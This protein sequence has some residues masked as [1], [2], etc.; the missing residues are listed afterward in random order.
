MN[1]R[2]FM[3][4]SVAAPVLLQ[5]QAEAGFTSLFTGRDLSGWSVQE[6]PESA[7]YVDK[8]DIVGTVSSDFPVWL[9]YDRQFENFD[10]RCEFFVKNWT[11][12]GVYFHAPE[13]GRNTWIGG[14]VKIFHQ[15][16]PDPRSNSMGSIFPVI[17]PKKVNVKNNGAWNSMRILMNWP[18]LTVWVNDETVQDLDMEQHPELRYRIRRG[19]MGLSALGYPLR[20]R[21]L[22]I[23]ELPATDR[24]D[25]LYETETDFS[26]WYISETDQR[27]PARFQA[28]NGILRGEG[29]G[30]LTT[31][32]KYKNFA[33]QL[34]IRGC[35]H[36]NGGVVFHG[37]KHYEI[38]I[39]NVEEAHY[40]TGSL[41]HFKRSTYPR[42]EDEKWYLMQIWV[43]EKNVV[44]RVNGEN[45]MEYD[46]LKEL[47]AGVIELQAHET[48]AWLEYKHIWI[49]R[50]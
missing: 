49:K 42:I 34:Y 30:L 39:H 11:D 25:H 6:G 28:L 41:Y 29:L 37:G 47:D 35:R 38:Q 7:F 19:F 9:R 43:R 50:L 26:K 12:G 4:A 33:L 8:G 15:I 31:K 20:F 2:D 1:R 36:H 48:N 5:A 16:D 22:R 14:Q 13:H 10:F 17:A 44:V 3:A 23:R 24:W 45:V 18:N 46:D 32:E 40:P 27:E 21:N